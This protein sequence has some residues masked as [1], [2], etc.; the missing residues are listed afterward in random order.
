MTK[1]I[2]TLVVLSLLA[3]MY[4]VIMIG[5]SNEMS[6]D[7]MNGLTRN[8][9]RDETAMVSMQSANGKVYN[10]WV[11][12]DIYQDG[13]IVNP[14]DYRFEVGT[15]GITVK[16]TLTSMSKTGAINTVEPLGNDM[17]VIPFYNS[18]GKLLTKGENLKKDDFI[19]LTQEFDTNTVGFIQPL[20]VTFWSFYGNKQNECILWGVQNQNWFNPPYITIYEPVVDEEEAYGWDEGITLSG[21]NENTQI[22]IVLLVDVDANSNG[23]N[24]VYVTVNGK[25]ISGNG[26]FNTNGK[27][28]TIKKGVVAGIYTITGQGLD[29]EFELFE[30]N[31]VF[32]HIDL[33]KSVGLK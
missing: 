5:C 8:H 2:N 10:F 7:P 21:S 15:T 6:T 32:T 1:R 14:A 13:K 33:K 20:G 11:D 27:T 29:I 30:E 12:V 23:Q 19:Y 24:S 17:K 3:L 16:Y 26:G 4:S 31:G 25:A 28:L 9:D 22:K 18:K